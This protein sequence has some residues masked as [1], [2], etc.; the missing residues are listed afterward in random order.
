MRLLLFLLLALVFA[1]AAAAASNGVES[2]EVVSIDPQSSENTQE[3]VAQQIKDAVEAAASLAQAT[4]APA[5]LV[6]KDNVPYSPEVDRC[7]LVQE[8]RIP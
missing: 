1:V 6:D 3:V 2:G 4:V 5:P 8:W 7:E